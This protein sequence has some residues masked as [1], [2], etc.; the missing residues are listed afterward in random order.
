MTTHTG[1]LI[2]DVDGP[3]DALA[4]PA[5]APGIRYRELDAL[6][7]LAALVVLV[8]HFRMMWADSLEWFGWHKWFNLSIM[9]LASGPESVNLFFLLSAFV[10][11]LPYL[12]GDGLE[13]PAYLARRV[14]R[15][16]GPYLFALALAVAGNAR[17]ALLV[18]S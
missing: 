13:Y 4:A 9:A 10:L 6:R 12:K 17:A 8:Y 14:I 7:G 2:K 16:Y 18:R 11:A 3:L 1:T 15:I 5:P